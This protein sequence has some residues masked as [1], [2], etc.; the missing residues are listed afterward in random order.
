MKRASRPP[1][2]IT[3][4]HFLQA[5]AGA[6][7]VAGLAALG[8]DGDSAPSILPGGNGDGRETPGASPS[9]AAQEGKR[10][11]RLRYTG[12][13]AGDGQYDPHRTQAGPFYGQQAAVF[14]RLLAYE[15]QAEGTLAPDL[16][17]K[18]PERPDGTTYIFKLHAQ[19]KWHDR[20]PL[21]GRAV[22]SGDVKFSIE[23]QRDGDAAFPRKAQWANVQSVEASDPRTVVVKSKAPLAAMAH[24][25]A[26]VNAFV[27][28]PELTPDGA[29]IG[30][31][32]QIGSGPFQWV[33]WNEGQFASLARAPAWFWGNDRPYLDGITLIQPADSSEVEA[34][35]RTKQIDVAFVGRP[36]ADRL[37]A[38]IQGLKESTFGQG[39]FWGMRFFSIIP[40]WD[41][42][43]VR[44]AVSIA[45]DRREMLREFFAGEGEMNAWVSWPSKRWALPAQELQSLPGYRAGAAG[46]DQDLAE[47]RAML[48]AYTSSG[49]RLP[50]LGLVVLDQAEQQFRMGSLL[51]AQLQRDLGLNVVVYPLGL[52][53]LI[54]GMLRGEY[55]WV[56]GPDNGWVD[57]DDWVYPYFHS[58]GT[59]NTFALRD[60]DLDARIDA[61][62][63]ELDEGKRRQL[64]YEIQRRLLQL[65]VGVNFVSERVVSLA[66]PYVKDFP[67]DMTDGYQHRFANTWI[68]RNH[69]SYRGVR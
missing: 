19:A 14:S 56:A 65:N 47:A 39:L 59:R 64:G 62:R 9:K 27:V 40:P 55:P 37:K 4:R 63:M 22:T 20:E 12:F 33:E 18:L 17:E 8:C 58:A 21:S 26:D 69:E 24:Y 45:I 50:E 1:H 34:R 23:R 29:S 41:D 28:P 10:G 61:Q 42:P 36:Q 60:A 46:R 57:L 32:Q 43:R 52:R 2:T 48:A 67:L 30:L 13:V 49:K 16:A 54:G 25:F 35:L 7:G 53:D 15:S 68:D 31:E 66:W 51:R 38:G 44:T 6:A 11:G 3:R 5:A